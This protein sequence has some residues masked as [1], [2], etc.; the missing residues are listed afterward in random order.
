[1]FIFT[2]RIPAGTSGEL[3]DLLMGLLRRNAKDRM[4][5]DNFFCHAFLQRPQSQPSTPAGGGAEEFKPPAYTAV[6][7]IAAPFTP[8]K[9]LSPI[10]QIQQQQQQQQI[11]MFFNWAHF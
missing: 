11:G 5:F 10:Q 4:S 1:M 7:F 6:K 8:P 2:R 3:C 9:P